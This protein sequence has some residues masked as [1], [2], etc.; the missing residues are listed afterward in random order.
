M[1]DNEMK[2]AVCLVDKEESKIGREI[3]D[4]EETILHLGEVIA[5]MVDKL[6]PIRSAYEH[7]ES[8]PQEV[9]TLSPVGESIRAARV[10]IQRQAEE[11]SSLIY[12]LEI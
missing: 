6:H 7:P 11:L 10:R 8:P 3:T 2:G 12:E 1:S 9:E 4:L 5:S